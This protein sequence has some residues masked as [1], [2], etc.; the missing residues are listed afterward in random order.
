MRIALFTETYLPHTNGVATHVKSLKDGLE[1]LG[2]E[3]L[4]VTAD[5]T[6][7]RHYI[8]DGVLHCPA[9]VSKRFY[10]YG[11]AMPISST[12]LKYIK[13]FKPDVIHVHNEF[14]IGISGMMIAKILRVALIYTLHTMYDEYIYYIAPQP[15]EPVAKKFSHEYTKIFAKAAQAL[16]GPSKKCEEYFRKVGVY[17]PVSV[18]PNPVDLV[19]FNANRFER[20]Q[21]CALREKFGY[22][23]E[24]AVA[25]FVGRLG[26]EKSVDILLDYWKEAIRPQEN[27]RLLVIGDGPCREELQKQAGELDIGDMVTF[28]GKIPHDELPPYLA[29]CD[30]YMTASTS[31]TNSISM[32]EAMATGLPV[33]QIVDPLNEGQIQEGVNGFIFS[34]AQEMHAKIQ[35]LRQ[36]PG[37]ER[38]ALRQT[39]RQSVERSGAVDLAN[40]VIS[41]YNEALGEKSRRSKHFILHLRGRTSARL[42][43]YKAAGFKLRLRKPSVFKLNKGEKNE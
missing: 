42:K 3:V 20:E 16:T 43:D 12:R 9:H 31:D 21:L 8:S 35:H 7:R 14:G 6:A 19:A 34:D 41:V 25:V 15:L 2:H 13:E 18:I 4:V 17:K 36:M 27:I 29:A 39:T 33:L 11:V 26:R 38:A 32:L 37:E 5:G 28:T 30:F 22:T 1:Q 10:G 23:D 24:M 40:Y